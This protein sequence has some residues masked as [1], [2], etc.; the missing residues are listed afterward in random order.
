MIFKNRNNYQNEKNVK[1]KKYIDYTKNYKT[2]K[3]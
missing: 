1:I 2:R 3:E